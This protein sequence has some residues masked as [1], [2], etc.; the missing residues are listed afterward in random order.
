MI[1]APAR[2]E[3]LRV[4]GLSFGV[5]VALGE[6]VGSGILRA[7]SLVAQ[8]I[9]AVGLILSL[10][11]AGAIHAGLQANVLAELGAMLPRVGGQ[12]VFVRR[13]LGEVPGLVVGWA[14]WSA[15]VAGIAASSIAFA[16]F[17]LPIVPQAAGHG[18][19]LAVGLQ[20]ALYGANILG[21]RE[22]R[23]LQ[24]TTSLLKA[25]LL[26]A[27]AAAA[28]LFLPETSGLPQ[29]SSPPVG[30]LMLAGSYQLIRGAYNG[31]HAPVYFAEENVV[32]SR[33]I[34]RALFFGIAVTATIYLV[35][36]A[37]L[38]R[39]LGPVGVAASA[40]PYMTVLKNIAGNGASIVFAI[41]AMVTVA[42]CANAN[43]MIAPRVLFAL[44]RDR[45]LPNALRAVNTGGSPYL[46][47]MLTAVVSIALATIGGFRM[48]F[49]MIA[50][51]VTL[52]SIVTE[53]S[54][55]V[56]RRREPKLAR[57]FRA[58]L[59]PLLPAL[60]V[61]LDAFLLLLFVLA[62]LRGAAL[63]AASCLLCVPFGILARRSW[64]AS[65][66]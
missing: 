29:Q 40:L 28:V 42:S 2:G 36:N 18:A 62:D 61:V 19:Q 33:N 66:G 30:L 35:V 53:I 21:L 17:L 41:G 55:F 27:F 14:M 24:T 63:A 65:T 51:L 45:L 7:P 39:A 59:Y 47:F 38:L 52:A 48:V 13:A 4:L 37:A 57:P 22:G 58:R 3:L 5:A 54:F 26:V 49:G 56:L 64:A 46:A 60:V 8:E 31:W 9:G 25:M 23:A 15:H 43:V 20:L 6:M 16:D 50:T 12:Y 34:P 44:S 11:L 1:L 10:W 32:P